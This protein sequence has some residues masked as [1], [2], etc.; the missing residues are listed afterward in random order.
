MARTDAQTN[1]YPARTHRDSRIADLQPGVRAT[2]AGRLLMSGAT[3]RLRD[4]SG[5]VPIDRIS[6][7]ADSIVECIGRWNPPTFTVDAVEVL[8]PSSRRPEAT[9]GQIRMRA[10][11]LRRTREFFHSR[12]FVEVETPL[13]V[14]TPG[15]EPHLRAFETLSQ[16]KT[17]RFL[18]TS[19]EYAMKRLLARGEE[20]IYQ[21]CK[22]FRDEP[23]SRFHSAE[24]TMLEWYRAFAS[25][26]DIAHDTEEL[27]S[28]L[29]E[30]TLGSAHLTV[31]SDRIALTPPWERLTVDE[32]FD[33]YA[34]IDRLPAADPRGFVQSC[35]GDATLGVTREDTFEDIFFRVFL[36]RVE[37]RLGRSKPTILTDYPASMAALAKCRDAAPHTA[38]RFEIFIGGIELTNAF[39]ELNDPV[40]QRE[41]LKTEAGE[42]TRHGMPE[43]PI[44]EAFLG[45]LE[46]GVPPAGG[47]ALGVDRLI[48]L[49]TESTHIRDVL[50]FP[51]PHI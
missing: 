15:M 27:V 10:R 4:A 8:A 20:R 24:F 45:A 5:E 43:Q 7:P 46:M 42:R 23:F 16:R 30:E 44:D 47:I 31:G 26:E 40:E 6:A 17:R 12:H 38:E 3:V 14:P 28:C 33:R 9:T 19:P 13:L 2:I 51:D 48:M 39:T 25:F 34:S 29:A 41:R 32:A 1:T 37:P 35:L 49:M 21:I 11:I 18:P 36:D 22:A 50:A